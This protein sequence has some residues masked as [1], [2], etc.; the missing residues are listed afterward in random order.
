MRLLDAG[1]ASEGL[2]VEPGRISD[3]AYAGMITRYWVEL[4]QGGELQVVRQNL[5]TSS[6]E[7]LGQRGRDVKVGWRPEHAVAVRE[8]HGDTSPG[9]GDSSE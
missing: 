5:E 3:V 8:D 2:Q 6:E 1:D 4:D 9:G 7:A